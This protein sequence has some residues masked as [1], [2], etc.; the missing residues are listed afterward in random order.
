[1]V[2]KLLIYSPDQ[3]DISSCEIICI[4]EALVTILT[5][6]DTYTL[7]QKEKDFQIIVMENE[8][9]VSYTG[10]GNAFEKLYTILPQKIA[11]DIRHTFK[12]S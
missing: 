2:R 5:K 3:P 12:D 10:T 1:M 4:G 6:V 11:N 8:K 7:L 9:F